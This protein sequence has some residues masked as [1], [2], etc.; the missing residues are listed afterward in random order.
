MIFI[1][2]KKIK[3]NQVENLNPQIV[4]CDSMMIFIKSVIKFL[5]SL[6]FWENINEFCGKYCSNE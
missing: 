6:S 3:I 5:R 1:C 2:N 4:I